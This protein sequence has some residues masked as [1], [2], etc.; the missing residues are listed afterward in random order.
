LLRTLAIIVAALCATCFEA[1]SQ[2]E[3]SASMSAT[4]SGFQAAAQPK[5][6]HSSRS[7]ARGLK[8]GLPSIFM[9]NQIVK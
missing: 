2:A 7:R 9:L 4:F 1:Y 6:A 5:R 3:I 8:P